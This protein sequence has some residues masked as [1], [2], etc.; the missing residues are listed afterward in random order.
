MRCA[1]RCKDLAGARMTIA[2]EFLDGRIDERQALD[3]TSQI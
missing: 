2:R 3:L 1:R